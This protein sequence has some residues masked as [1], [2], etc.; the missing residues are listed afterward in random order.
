MVTSY[1]SFHYEFLYFNILDNLSSIVVVSLLLVTF[2]QWELLQIGP[3][4]SDISLVVFAAF[5]AV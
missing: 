4:P 5:F 2:G 3:S 1:C